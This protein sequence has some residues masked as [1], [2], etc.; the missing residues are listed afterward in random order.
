MTST[1]TDSYKKMLPAI[2]GLLALAAFGVMGL[3]KPPQRRSTHQSQ[4]A[5]PLSFEVASIKESK[6]FNM[7]KV[8]MRIMN[9]PN[10]G[11]FYGTNL[12]LK[13]LIQMAYQVQ[14]SQISGGPNWMNS[15]RFDIQAK[16]DSAVNSRLAKMNPYE[17]RLAK[18]RMLQQFLT[19]RFKL[20]IKRETKKLPIFALVVSKHGPRI[21]PVKD[22][23][24]RPG[25]D[26]AGPGGHVAM[27]H[28][29][30][31]GQVM[32]RPGE[33]TVVDSTIANLAHLLSPM[34]GRTVQDETGLKGLYSF[35]LQ[36]TPGVGERGIVGGPGP[37][38]AMGPGGNIS[39]QQA[40]AMAP[41]SGE[42]SGPVEADSSGPSIFTAL[43][44]QL[45]LKLKPEKGPVEI[46]VIE[47]AEHPTSD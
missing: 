6:S 47:H 5:V 4:P 30:G 22:V 15:D 12:T 45:G 36:W 35:T 18:S 42:G 7:R 46:L 37:G 14:G 32:M 39:G 13:M 8:M 33:M 29:L 11:R 25:P 26:A 9:P 2:A 10:D 43:Q 17:G 3:A 31:L 28:G 41:A 40:A 34:L 16:S 20:Q 23:P 21:K 19:D 38:A 1:S 24:L 27:G 44:Q